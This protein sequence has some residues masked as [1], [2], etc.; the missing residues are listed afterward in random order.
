MELL[1]KE[2]A[3]LNEKAEIYEG[4]AF[5]SRKT[6]KLYRVEQGVIREETAGITRVSPFSRSFLDAIENGILQS[7]Q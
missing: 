3:Y 6:G 4:R 2:K 1:K 5:F 7:Q